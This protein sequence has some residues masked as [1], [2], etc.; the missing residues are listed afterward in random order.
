VIILYGEVLEED[1]HFIKNRAF[2]ELHSWKR[3]VW[4]GFEEFDY[5]FVVIAFELLVKC[6]FDFCG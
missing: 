2:S 5:L 3:E 1:T 4:S 6:V